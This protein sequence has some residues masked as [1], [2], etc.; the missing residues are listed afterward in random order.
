MNTKT[1][2][3]L[4]A[5][6]VALEALI[7]KLVFMQSHLFGGEATQGHIDR[8]WEDLPFA[9]KASLEDGDDKE[10]RARIETEA[11]TIMSAF[12]KRVRRETGIEFDVR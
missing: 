2:I 1:E 9:L 8:V 3:R 12:L 11:E 7:E 5:R 4:R 10:M 6:V